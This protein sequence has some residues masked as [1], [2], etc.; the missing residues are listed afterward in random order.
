MKISY[1]ILASSLSLI[2]IQ[3]NAG[4]ADTMRDLRSTLSQFNETSKEVSN[5]AREWTGSRTNNTSNYT[6]SS[7]TV[8]QQLRPKINNLP[9]YQSADKSGVVLNKLSKSADIIFA[10]NATKT[11]LIEVTTEYGNG[12]I[13]SHLVQ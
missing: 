4:F 3:S 13:E 5:T 1:L 6:N 9:L 10:G 12:W 11:G 2:C 8:G 7:F